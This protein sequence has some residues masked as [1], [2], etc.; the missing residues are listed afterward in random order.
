[1]NVAGKTKSVSKARNRKNASQVLSSA[2]LSNAPVAQ[3]YN[4]PPCGNAG[5]GGCLR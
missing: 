1:M 3:F 5:K 4:A 2:S